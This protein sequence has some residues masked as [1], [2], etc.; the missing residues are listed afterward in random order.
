MNADVELRRLQATRNSLFRTIK[1]LS[2]VGGP[3]TAL[4]PIELSLL[5]AARKGAEEAA[6]DLAAVCADLGRRVNNG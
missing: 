1:I 3:E 4:L 2:K 5:D 6:A